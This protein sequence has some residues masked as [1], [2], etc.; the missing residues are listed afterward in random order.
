VNS[1][2]TK[3]VTG[4][5]ISEGSIK[6]CFERMIDFETKMHFRMEDRI[7]DP[8]AFNDDQHKKE[9]SIGSQLFDM[10]ENWIKGSKNLLAGI[11]RTD[12]ALDYQI[13]E[14]KFVMEPELFVFD[15]CI[16]FIKQM[17]EYTWAEYKGSSA[18]DKEKSGRP[19][20]KNDHQPENLHR[21]LLHEPRF[22]PA[23]LRKNVAI[24][25]SGSSSIAE[26]DFDP[27]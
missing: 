7:I 24:K 11:K 2:G 6:L 14:G 13:K 9:K 19:K 10:G 22:I 27:Y 5:V 4:E 17:E 15:T 16:T 1:R 21:L 23:Q 26:S 18:D 8:S 12:A 25:S 3:I 20:D